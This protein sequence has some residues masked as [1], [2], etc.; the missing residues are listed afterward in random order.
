MTPETL[1][2]QAA[3]MAAAFG[4]RIRLP[5]D[6]RR[7]DLRRRLA[8]QM[9]DVAMRSPFYRRLWGL[10]AGDAP[11]T[12]DDLPRLPFT[13]RAM[14]ESSQAAHPPFGDY[15]AAPPAR[16]ARVHRTSGSGGR[17]L[18]I[19]LS[20]GD[21]ERTLRCGARAF[22]FA[23]VRPDDLIVHCLNYCMWSGGVSDHQAL[24]RAGAGVIPFGVGHTTE[25]IHALRA[26]RPSGI[27]CTPS[28][29]GR[30][31][32]RLRAEFGMTPD[33]LGLRIGLFGGEPGLQ[34]PAFRRRIEQ[35]WGLRAVDANYGMSEVLSIFGA[36]CDARQGLHFTGGG[37]LF[38]EIR[39][40]DDARPPEVGARGELVLTHLRRRCQP[41]VRYRTG[42]VVEIVGDG[43]CACGRSGLRFAVLGRADDM[44]VVRGVNVYLG[45]VSRV[46][47]DRLDALT[48]EF[49]L[50]VS[51][52]PPVE[53]CRLRAE[54]KNE[55]AADA[56]RTALERELQ[57]ALRV[58]VDV[59]LVPA[60]SLPRTDDK[61]RR[62][63]R[64][65]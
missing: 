21:V 55:S 7:T 13:T 50:Q 11:L 63:E 30:I 41:L 8:R 58:R 6:L 2:A 27:H 60:G 62:L 35:T 29:L 39:D 14:L 34:S 54:L 28:Y 57:Q 22:R 44:V 17:P 15:L 37:A 3:R 51:R 12:A 24:E 38:P 43:P 25:L 26:L 61:T 48:G 32:E 23:G 33:Q 9:G 65:L 10:T 18:A 20:R 42:D 53:A 1:N 52:T 59:E 47:F 19:A 5:R 56:V 31:E 16:I 49:R 4:I 40:G 45:A 64:V 46:V 36:E